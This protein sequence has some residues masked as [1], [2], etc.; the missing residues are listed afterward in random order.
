M[1]ATYA[2]AFLRAHVVTRQSLSLLEKSAERAEE[3]A[4][5]DMG[6]VYADPAQCL[7]EA[8][9][10]ILAVKPQD[11]GVLLMAQTFTGTSE[12]Y[13]KTEANL[14]GVDWACG[15]QGWDYR[16]CTPFV[17]GGWVVQFD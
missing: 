11:V 1:G 7:P 13:G 15:Q 6:T 9:L 14:Y 2:R 10:V 12:L 3:L 17:W 5:E 8:D 4:R 16:S